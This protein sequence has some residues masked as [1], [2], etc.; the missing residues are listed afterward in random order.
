MKILVIKTLP[1]TYDLFLDNEKNNIFINHID[2]KT[3]EFLQNLIEIKKDEVEYKYLMNIIQK[4]NYQKVK[5]VENKGEF[6]IKGE[7]IRIW[8]WHY[9]CPI[10]FLFDFEEI[11]KV[12]IIYNNKFINIDQVF[13][14]DV[15]LN[16]LQNIEMSFTNF[17]KPLDEYIKVFTYHIPNIVN[18]QY[19]FL[20]IEYLYTDFSY[21]SLY[22]SNFEILKKDLEQYNQNNY[23]IEIQGGIKE[24]SNYYQEIKKY[25][26]NKNLPENNLSNKFP[27]FYQK[28]KTTKL[29]AGFISNSEKI[30]CLTDREIFGTISLDKSYLNKTNKNIEKN[31]QKLL[32]KLQGSIE[33]GDFIVHEDYGIGIYKGLNQDRIEDQT[34][35]FIDI[36][37]ANGDSVLFPLD[38]LKKITKYIGP[39]GIKPKLTSLRRNE[40]LNIKCKAK[41]SIEIIAKDLI[42]HYAKLKLQKIE[43]MN[44]IYNSEIYQKFVEEFKFIETD[45]QLKAVEEIIKDMSQETPMNRLLIGDVGFG[46]TE[47][48]LRIA[49]KVIEHGGQVAVL[50]PT[51][52]LVYQH[53]KTFLERFKKF[54]IKIGYLSRF[55]TKSENKKIIEELK[56]G[57]LDLVV[58]THRL[59]SED[60]AFKNLKLLI[61]DEEQRFGVKQKEK[62]RKLNLQTHLLGVSATPI[63]RTLSMAL[64]SIYNLSIISKPPHG[65]MQV[66]TKIIKYN[67]KEIRDIISFEI[68]RGGQ[69]FFVVNNIDEIYTTKAKLEFLL[70]QIKIEVA[71]GQ[72][73]S[74]NLEEIMLNFIN[75]KID[76]LVTTT[77]I[78]NGIDIH[79][80]NTIIIK[81]AQNFGLG[82]LH[83]LR[84]RIGRSNVQG[85][86]YLI[87]NEINKD[88]ELVKKEQELKKIQKNKINQIERL[89]TLVDNQ[90]LGAG[91]RIA[92]RDLEIR[93]AGNLLG[94]EQSGHINSIGFALYVR[95]LGEVIEKLSLKKTNK[96]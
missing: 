11:T 52:V 47:V 35:Q 49:F 66:I 43:K 69:V 53:Y 32:D 89:Q 17:S 42:E 54:P 4:H 27:F 65:K 78:E 60:I 29:V 71:H 12:V 19:K 13:F 87:Y 24:I 67:D 83:Q 88:K 72:M 61:I 39:D 91:F 62:I 25:I 92:S 90:D 70:P 30:V 2:D 77:I 41:K 95:I 56:S 10:D 1:H 15:E 6:S 36:E 73:K 23:F 44:Y 76:C 85:Y 57:Y 81:D 21:P 33:I 45:D 94:E 22:Y 16:V 31:Y 93:G 8:L 63:P 38:N 26:N 3:Y 58:G 75:K 55:N 5:E 80:V 40:W 7:N 28:L 20:P 96:T 51:T 79:N 59:L 84:G 37:F 68:Q 18:N 48:F 64:S 46:K 82:Q 50:A 14:S 9:P 74:N 86:C 34:L